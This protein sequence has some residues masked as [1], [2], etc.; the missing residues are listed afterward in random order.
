MTTVEIT[1]IGLGQIGTSIG[2]ALA[3]Q[4]TSVHRVGVDYEQSNTRAANKM[5]ALDQAVHNIPSAVR[6]A[7]LVIL[8]LPVDEVQETLKLI[9][10]ELHPGAVVMNTSPVRA[11]IDQWAKEIMPQDRYFISVTPTLNP[12]YLPGQAIGVNAARADL[13]KNSLMIITT[14]PGTNPDAIKLATDL[15]SL[16]G[17]KPYFADAVEADGLLAATH[18]LPE[19]ISAA[20]MNT[21]MDQ[22][23]WREARKLAGQPFYEVTNPILN[24]DEDKSLGQ[25]AIL[26]RDNVVRMLDQL[27]LSLQTLRQKIAEKD[28]A[29]L[30]KLITHALE[31]RLNW[32]HERQQGYWEGAPMDASLSSGNA[33]GRLFGIGTRPKE[34]K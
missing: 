5:G 24:L 31:G 25:A 17:A 1:I 32:W 9:A 2:L 6:T 30:S 29:G 23:G 22:P 15:A 33:F 13:F 19:L 34:N 21:V 3:E 7:D 20:L 12:A 27:I 16:L 8:A 28:N 4:K 26:N 10:G 11:A 14:P 18:F